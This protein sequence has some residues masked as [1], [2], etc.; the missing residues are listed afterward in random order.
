M[1][2]RVAY[3]EEP[4]FYWT[5]EDGLATGADVELAKVVLG[6]A[7]ETSIDFVPTTFDE[8]IPGVQAGRWDMNV[9]IFVTPDRA[10]RVAFS[11]P[12]WSLGD[13]FL[14]AQ[15]NPHALTSYAAVAEHR[16]ARLGVIPG[17]V[18]FAAAQS[19]GVPA[20]RIVTFANQPD[21]VDALLA[22]EI[23]AFAATTIGN[24]AVV[25]VTPGLDAVP[26]V[27]DGEAAAPVGAFS[28]AMGNEGLLREV[29]AQLREYLGS[30]DHRARMA[31]YG[32][33]R[34]E[35]DGALP[36]WP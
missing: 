31:E 3:V 4:P 11:T 13:G 8:L 18:Q 33:T 9:P 26:V 29:N 24:R 12:V 27:G 17:Q 1:T 10:E 19:A 20:N 5:T 23:D 7:G 28:F 30:A 32:I 34:A 21:A 25:A 15:G 6:A 16:N 22:G 14:V 36:A 2:V 35:I